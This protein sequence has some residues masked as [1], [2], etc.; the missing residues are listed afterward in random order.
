[1]YELVPPKSWFQQDALHIIVTWQ[2]KRYRKMSRRWSGG[3]LRSF[4]A[5]HF[6]EKTA[7]QL[8]CCLYS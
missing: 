7:L 2:A 5:E 3:G 1:M 6:G 4:A 8:L